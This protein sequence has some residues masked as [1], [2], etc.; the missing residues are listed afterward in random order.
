MA[1]IECVEG[2]KIIRH[3]EEVDHKLSLVVIQVH[4]VNV[5]CFRYCQEEEVNEFRASKP[6]DKQHPYEY[7]HEVCDEAVSHIQCPEDNVEALEEGW[8]PGSVKCRSLYGRHE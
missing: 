2:S 6:S 1:S 4:V 5:G 3:Q 8:K 7:Q